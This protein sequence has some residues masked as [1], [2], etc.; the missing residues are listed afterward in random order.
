LRRNLWSN[1]A[2]VAYKEATV[3]RHDPALMAAILIQP[4]AQLLLLGFALSNKP[5]NVPWAILDENRTS[6]SRRFIQEVQATGYFLEP[7]RVTGYDAGRERIGK[8]EALA[9]LVIPETF[10][11]DIERRRPRVQLLL[12]GSDPLSVARIGGYV[13]EVAASFQV[14]RGAPAAHDPDR[15]IREPSP[16]DVRQRFRFNPTL[17]DRNFYMAALAA[18]VLTNLTLSAMALG[19]V[20]ERESGTYEQMLALPTTPIE[21][22]LGKLLPYVAVSYVVLGLCVV[23]PG[24]IFGIWPRGSWIALGVVTLPFVL[25]SLGIGV[26]VSALAHTSAQAVFISV[27]FIMPSFVLSG[28][29]LP[30]QLMPH[31]VREIGGMFPL[32]WYQI[33]LRRIVERGAGLSEVAFPTLVLVGLFAVMLAAIRWRMKPRLG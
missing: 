29:M 1:I 8:G 30:Y 18:M 17:A 3:M 5:A 16:I 22:V 14:E 6:I 13:A 28:A 21:I 19:L 7:Q 2:A 31:P 15:A 10:A 26:F 9:M 20:A 25:A 24:L 4:M 23:A 11:R 33:A 27:F 12:D 32:R